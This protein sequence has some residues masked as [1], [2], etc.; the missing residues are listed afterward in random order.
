MPHH[1][2][3]AEPNG[4]RKD[5]DLPR[6]ER[7]VREILLA[8]GEDPDREGLLDTPK[9]VAKAYAQIC[10]GLWEDAGTHLARTFEH[11]SEGSIVTLK[12][13]EF[14]SVCEHHLLPFKG[15]VHIAYLP[16][17][18]RVVGLSKL[19]RTVEVFAR[20]PQLQ[21]QLTGQIADALV[22]HL[23]PQGV[24]VVAQ[25]EHMCMQ[26]RGVCKSDAVMTTVVHRGAFRDD[27]TQRSEVLRLLGVA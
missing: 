7:A 26:M 5:P 20:R 17:A 12:N 3:D 22:Q 10:G 8:L 15:H 11:Q 21:E 1:H 9:R 6:I 16:S 25:A 23:D 24:T 19:A 18:D 13:I 14:F 27:A 4:H 2:N